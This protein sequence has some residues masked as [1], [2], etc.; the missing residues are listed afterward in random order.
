MTSI[1]KPHGFYDKLQEAE[2][3]EKKI[4]DRLGRFLFL[5]KVRKIPYDP[6][7]PSTVQQQKEGVDIIVESEKAKFDVKIRDNCYYKKGILIEIMS[8]VEQEK[9]GWFYTSKAHAIIYAWW[10]KQKSNL[11]REGFLILHQD[12]RL[13]EWFDAKKEKYFTFETHSEQNG[14]LWTTHFKI[15]P[16]NDFPKG[17]LVPFN[18]QLP[19]EN[20]QTKLHPLF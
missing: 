16:I 4:K 5:Q 12:S 18:A 17:T 19:T 15:V 9:L 1:R 8:V 13:R 11:M 2:P 10:N 14:N 3:F 6:Q 7:N 20:K